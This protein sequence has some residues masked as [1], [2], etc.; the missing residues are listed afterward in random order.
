MLRICRGLGA[1]LAL[2]L[3][4]VSPASAQ[5]AI[6]THHYDNARTGWNAQETTLTY[7]ALQHPPN[8]TK[9]F[10]LL[11]AVKLDAQVD[12]Q[13]LVVPNAIIDGDPNAG[14]HDVA[15]VATG[16]NTV[17]A[18]DSARGTILNARTLGPPVPLP[19]GC[20]NN[21]TSVGI[22]G[23]PVIDTTTNS[24]YVMAYLSYPS[25]PQ[26]VLHRL[27][28]HDF[29]DVVPPTLVAA[30]HSLVDGS[31]TSFAA[32]Y[33]RHRAALLLSNG[34]VYA[35]FAS[36][37]D[38]S[39]NKSRGW[40]LGWRAD[41]L[42]PLQ[43]NTNPG[44]LMALL[45]DQLAKSPNNFFLSSI[46]M[47]GAGPAADAQGNIFLVTGNSDASG[48]TY[49]GVT[50]V[51]NSAIKFNPAT[52]QILSLF[53]PSAVKILD[54]EDYDFGSGGILLLPKSPA[55][56]P[57][58]L[59]VAAGKSGSMYL[60]NRDSLG[61]FADGDGPDDVVGVAQIG[62]CW[63]QP[64][65]FENHGT[66]YLV[67][68]GSYVIRIWS[69]HGTGTPMV[70]GPKFFLPIRLQ[71]AGS[72]TTV[73][74]NGDDDPVIWAIAGPVDTSPANLTL[75]AFAPPA[76]TLSTSNLT[77]LYAGVAGTWPNSAANPNIVPVVAN[78]KVYVATYR[79]LSI[80]GLGGH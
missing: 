56:L 64:S 13:P 23:T 24:L 67:S 77:Q 39:V 35:G 18:I 63:C 48:T 33:Q 16:N 27:A 49:N 10:G 74:S 9:A 73:S 22:T 71:D 36:F 2:V 46:W 80:F 41:T 60:M 15:F 30:T 19:L 28:L 34:A 70:A 51:Q 47:S 6:T 32:K 29:S 55:G 5:F 58:R 54:Q 3:A 52:N 44:A 72:F 61:G 75:Y 31:T 12:A 8:A 26:Y 76:S 20:K 17:Y 25:G 1:I 4:T 69:L 45:P 7:A 14:T 59:A 21:A 43:T 79:Q 37:C 78:G 53:T 68:S 65:Y 62:G 57:P 38:F 40:L 66:L 42:A 50:N 11:H